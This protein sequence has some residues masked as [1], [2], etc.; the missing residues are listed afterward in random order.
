M[1]G[2]VGQAAC[3]SRGQ[4]VAGQHSPAPHS[5]APAGTLPTA[6]C[7]APSGANQ[8]LCWNTGPSYQQL[9]SGLGTRWREHR[10]RKGKGSQLSSVFSQLV[11][12][13]Y[14]RQRMRAEIT[15]IFE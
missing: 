3:D 12:S 9:S 6:N 10:E 11:Y 1:S 8:D 14:K 5:C 15:A 13:V 7:A 4:D 2:A